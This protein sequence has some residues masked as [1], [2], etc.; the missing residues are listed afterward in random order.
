MRCYMMILVWVF[1]VVTAHAVPAQAQIVDRGCLATLEET[2]GTLAER[3]RQRDELRAEL[4]LPVAQPSPALE[5]DCTAKL[6]SA[7]SSAELLRLEVAELA[8]RLRLRAEGDLGAAK[9]SQL[10]WEVADLRERSAKLEAALKREQRR[11]RARSAPAR[12]PPAVR[13][14]PVDV[15][16]LQLGIALTSV[17]TGL[18]INS[19]LSAAGAVVMFIA[20]TATPR[21]RWGSTH[22]DFFSDPLQTSA[23]SLAASALITG[24]LGGLLLYFGRVPL[25]EAFQP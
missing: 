24:P 19:A 4:G 7:S 13:T 23:A 5:G 18:V 22:P 14:Q 15:A 1:A 6:K 21:S 9:A 12:K 11:N 8:E 25:E 10:E 3:T 17:G 20:S 16:S 2:L